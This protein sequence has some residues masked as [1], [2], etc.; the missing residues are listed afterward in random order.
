MEKSLVKTRYLFVMVRFEK[1]ILLC[2]KN[3]IYIFVEQLS[4]R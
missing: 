2:Q 4:T 3:D 1:F